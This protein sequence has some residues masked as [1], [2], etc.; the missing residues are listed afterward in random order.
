MA[1]NSP[2]QVFV[3]WKLLFYQPKVALRGKSL[4]FLP[5]TVQKQ[6]LFDSR[7]RWK[8][9]WRLWYFGVIIKFLLADPSFLSH[10]KSLFAFTFCFYLNWTQPICT[11]EI[12]TVFVVLCCWVE[13]LS[14]V[15]VCS[16]P[17]YSE[18]N[19]LSPPRKRKEK[20]KKNWLKKI[21]GTIVCLEEWNLLWAMFNYLSV[22]G[23]IMVDD[24]PKQ[25]I[26]RPE[27]EMENSAC[28]IS[29][30]I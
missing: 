28:L 8:E 17:S 13:P 2:V 18:I 4:R 9:K 23:V 26:W 30:I 3:D 6:C 21:I 7:A 29:Y 11:L 1:V 16:E 22:T 12:R 27:T 14:V 10:D 5:N 25:T 15:C 20:K 19:I 24:E